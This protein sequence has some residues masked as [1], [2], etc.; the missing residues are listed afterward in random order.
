[1]DGGWLLKIKN[2]SELEKLQGEHARSWLVKWPGCAETDQEVRWAQAR[3]Y[4]TTKDNFCRNFDIFILEARACPLVPEAAWIISEYERLRF[5][6]AREYFVGIGTKDFFRRLCE[7]ARPEDKTDPIAVYYHAHSGIVGFIMDEF[8]R[9]RDL[10]HPHAAL[11][12]VQA[13]LSAV[14]NLYEH[15]SDYEEHGPELDGQWHDADQIRQA[16]ADESERLRLDYKHLE[17][18]I[19]T[20]PS[21]RADVIYRLGL[22]TFDDTPRDVQELFGFYGP[23]GPIPEA[24][25][26]TVAL[27]EGSVCA[28]E[29][30]VCEVGRKDAPV[31]NQFFFDNAPTI[32][33]TFLRTLAVIDKRLASR[34]IKLIC[35]TAIWAEEMC[36]LARFIEGVQDH[37]EIEVAISRHESESSTGVS[38][39][40]ACRAYRD[41]CR[42]AA[43]AWCLC[44]KQMGMH[45]DTRRIIARYIWGLRLYPPPFSKKRTGDGRVV[46][47]KTVGLWR[48]LRQ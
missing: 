36:L 42:E 1:M 19:D 47:K 6:V 43:M 4:C 13:T 20:A 39:W 40:Q 7:H 22:Y 44:A 37:D 35:L 15:L 28:A 32:A 25:L 46:K 24:D 9:A 48:K 17:R 14:I 33:R 34:M 2:E 11:I 45:K 26:M 27:V 41:A 23:D 29:Y 21:I 5:K 30:W 16:I 18:A 8:K 38:A 12:C 31:P 3:S 10:G